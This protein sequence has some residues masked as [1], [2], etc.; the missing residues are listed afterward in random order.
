MSR[1]T[2]VTLRLATPDQA[3]ASDPSSQTRLAGRYLHQLH[4]IAL[5]LYDH[6]L[7]R[8]A[9]D[10]CRY[11]TLVEPR[12]PSH[13][14]WLGR[15][16]VALGDPAGAGQVFELGGRLS[17]RVQFADLA[18]DAWLRAGHPDRAEAAI[19]LKDSVV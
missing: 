19:A 11:L 6:T 10:L 15:A 16:L 2:H 8:E 7:Y 17:H 4:A 18:A 1:P 14:Y 5:E 13:W 12:N 9:S 3:K